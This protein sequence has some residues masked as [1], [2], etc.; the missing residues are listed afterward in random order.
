M[1]AIQI[2]L[3]ARDQASTQIR[4]VNAE[5]AGLNATVQKSNAGFAAFAGGA[6]IAASAAAAVG[7]MAVRAALELASEVEALNNAAQAAGIARGELYALSAV[8]EDTANVSMPELLVGLRAFNKAIQ[9]GN[10]LLAQLGVKSQDTRTAL[11]QLAD[12]YSKLR[13]GSFKSTSAQELLGRSGGRLIG[14]LNQGS[15]AIREQVAEMERYQRAVIENADALGKLDD[16]SDRIKRQLGSLS[17]QLIASLAPALLTV[18]SAISKMLDGFSKLITLV[19]RAPW[20]LALFAVNPAQAAI[21]AAQLGKGGAGGGAAPGG[22]D[23]GPPAAPGERQPFEYNIADM[24]PMNQT[25]EEILVI[26]R[27]RGRLRREIVRGW[28]EL[29]D[30]IASLANN[31]ATT[32]DAAF[33]GLTAGFQQVAVNLIGTSQTLRT[34]LITIFRSM[35]DAILAELARIAAA[36]VFRTLLSFL[37][38]GAGSAAGALL[39]QGFAGGVSA[40][41]SRQQGPLAA[42]GGTTVH[43]HTLN[44]RDVAMDLL[45]PFGSLRRGND[46]VTVGRDY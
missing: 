28:Q 19:A 39:G 3:Q 42:Q 40:G 10:P 30:D 34:A 22:G 46:L 35:V 1:N 24:G 43:I 12:A 45:S 5:V 37:A 11:G 26:G 4:Q 27:D 33:F 8:I 31:F 9:D 13:D 6:A 16:V 38:P 32:L 7:A 36:A 2:L 20:L 14:V 29:F 21:L 41:P 44:P 18:A 17:D 15:E 25:V 23:Q